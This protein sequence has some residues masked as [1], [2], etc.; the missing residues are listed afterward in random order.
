[1]EASCAGDILKQ[2]TRE[3][4]GSELETLLHQLVA[5]QRYRAIVER[6]G[7]GSDIVQQLLVQNA[8]GK[9]FFADPDPLEALARDLTTALRSVSVD[10]DTEHNAHLLVVEDRSGGFAR[11]QTVGI[12][13]VESAE[14]RALLASYRATDG[15]TGPMV[16]TGIRH[17]GGA[18]GRAP[19]VADTVRGRDAAFALSL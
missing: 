13:F 10:V 6:R 5:F 15:V 8:D 2:G 3:W 4:T 14:Y 17:L 19:A 18:A 1:M 7:P 11:R 9:A 16:V 12:E